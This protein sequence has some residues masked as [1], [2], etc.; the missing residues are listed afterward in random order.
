MLGYIANYG[1]TDGSGDYYITIDGNNCDGCAKCVAACP[2]NIIEVILN[3]YDELVAE[4][5]SDAVK[6][7]KY[8]CAPCKPVSSPRE[9]KCQMACPKGAITHSW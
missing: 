4:V 3:D 5:R 9:L 7:L 6:N 8:I 1:Y 2:E